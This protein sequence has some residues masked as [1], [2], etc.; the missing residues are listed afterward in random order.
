MWVH[1]LV[2]GRGGHKWVKG[3]KGGECTGRPGRE[4]LSC[5]CRHD[6]PWEKAYNKER[7]EVVHPNSYELSTP[8]KK[9][10]QYSSRC[11]VR[12]IA[13]LDYCSTRSQKIMGRWEDK[14]WLSRGL[15]S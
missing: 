8:Y 5:F 10:P 4:F 3:D 6:W 14:G 15:S 13:L 9:Y 7:F 11:I 1:E 2:K 12:A